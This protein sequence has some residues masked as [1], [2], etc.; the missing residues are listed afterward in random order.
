MAEGMA[1]LEG[2]AAVKYAFSICGVKAEQEKALLEQ[3]FPNMD[4]VAT[5][6]PKDLE[7]MFKAIGKGNTAPEK[8]ARIGAMLGRNIEGLVY[9]CKERKRQGLDLDVRLV[10]P[11]ALADAI[12]LMEM[13][14]AEDEAKA[15]IPK[16]AFEPTKWVSWYNSVMN[17]LRAVRGQNKV[18][19]VY[20]VRKD[21][22]ADQ[23]FESAEEERIYS[24]KLSGKAYDAD[25]KKVY[26]ILVELL[27]RTSAWTYVSKFGK[28]EDGRGAMDSLRSHY[29]GK[30]QS[31]MRTAHAV[32]RLLML[33]MKRKRSLHLRS[34]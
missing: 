22:K 17:Y 9:W 14:D 13:D 23:P 34:M 2:E 19:L 21:R 5:T 7:N 12:E 16:L 27:A 1:P 20:V 33:A 11:R 28:K 31:A 10:T 8:A 30:G 4:T 15:E 18:P 25:N 3:G 29:N 26:N 24:I 6:R 32:S